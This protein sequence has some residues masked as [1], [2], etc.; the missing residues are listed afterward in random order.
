RD[1]PVSGGKGGRLFIAN[2]TNTFGFGGTAKDR[3]FEVQVYDTV[4][5]S[6]PRN[7][8]WEI[9]VVSNNAASIGK[10]VD[11]WAYAS[12]FGSTGLSAPIVQGVDNTTLVGEPADGDSVI[13]VGAYATKANW[14]SCSSGGCGYVTPR[15]LGQI[16]PFSSIGPR[17]D[18]ALKPDLTAPGFG[19][20]TTHS[21]SAPAFGVCADADDGQHE[22]TQGTSFASPHVAGAAALFL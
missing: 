2:Q 20:A 11:I 10:R 1:L 13:A 5:T 7:G 15:T 16:A 21:S 8:T 18:G 4:A 17:R 14:T 6:A 9:D 19:L 3:Q 22:I 12:S